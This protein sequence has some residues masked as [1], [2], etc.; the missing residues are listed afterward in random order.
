M[1]FYDLHP[2]TL[3][4]YFSSVIT[5]SMLTLN[6]VL[7]SMSFLGAFIAVCIINKKTDW[8][9][10]SIVFIMICITNPLFSH[11]GET[12]LFYLFDQRITLEALFYGF[13]AAL[14]ILSVIYWFKLFSFVF[15]QDKLTWLVGRLSPKL[16]VVF[17]MALRFIPM[18]KENA[19]N[20]YNAQ[21]SLNIFDTSKIKGK[22]MLMS[23]VFS[24]LVS[25][26]IENA[27]ETADTMRARGFDGKKRSSY[28]QL[29]FSQKNM[30]VI[31]TIVALDLLIGYLMFRGEGAFY[32]YPSIQFAEFSCATPAFYGLYAVLNFIPVI[33]ELAEA[34]RWKYLISKI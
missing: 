17:C 21:L 12:V 15:T 6:P 23:N 14:L 32:Y 30:W 22:I 26:S 20:I 27:I 34:I 28:S 8:I 31:T 1:S 18:F 9:M 29:V 2:L 19:K 13:G 7:L 24:T 16:C 33:I 10:Y 4:I 25:M 5:F 11:N 3:I